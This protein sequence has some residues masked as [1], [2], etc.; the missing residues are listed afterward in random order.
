MPPGTDKTP[1]PDHCFFLT[2]LSPIP[3]LSYAYLLPILPEDRLGIGGGEV[4]NRCGIG[5]R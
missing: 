4:G 1:L 3:C 5:G 2:Y